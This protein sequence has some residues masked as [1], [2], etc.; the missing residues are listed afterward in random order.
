VGICAPRRQT[1]TPPLSPSF[2][3]NAGLCPTSMAVKAKVGKDEQGKG[4]NI[5]WEPHKLEVN[6][7]SPKAAAITLKTSSPES[8]Q[9]CGFRRRRR[10]EDKFNFSGKC[11]TEYNLENNDQLATV[12]SESFRGRV[13]SFWG[14]G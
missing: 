1:T 5:T 3:N 10:R 7:Y 8:M 4:T 14:R 2:L 12:P 13:R 11:V 6:I 9:Y